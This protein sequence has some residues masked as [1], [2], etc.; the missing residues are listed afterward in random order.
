VH[1]VLASFVRALTG[2]GCGCAACCSGEQQSAGC[3]KASMP[4]VDQM[5]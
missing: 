1:A 5:V 2:V 3:E 4:M